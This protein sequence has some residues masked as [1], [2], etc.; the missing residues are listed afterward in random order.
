MNLCVKCGKP[1][2]TAGH[3]FN[4]FADLAIHQTRVHCDC[5]TEI[6]RLKTKLAIAVEALTP[7]PDIAKHN[8]VF[9]Q[10]PV[11]SRLRQAVNDAAKALTDIEA[12]K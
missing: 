4:C 7:F 3:C 11:S 5:K 6:D 9:K 2:D 8:K 10:L 1:L 12:V